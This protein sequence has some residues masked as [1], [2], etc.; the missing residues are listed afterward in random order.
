MILV[1]K[2]K[3]GLSLTFLS[4]ADNCFNSLMI[5]LARNETYSRMMIT[6]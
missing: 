1:E 6:T 3:C 5:F 4:L 2:Y